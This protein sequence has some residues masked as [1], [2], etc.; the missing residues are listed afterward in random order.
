MTTNPHREK[1]HI[2]ANSAAKN[3][4]WKGEKNPIYRNGD[5]RVTLGTCLG[6]ATSSPSGLFMFFV[7]EELFRSP[8]AH[9]TPKFELLV[10]QGSSKETRDPQTWGAIAL[11]MGQ[12]RA[13]LPN[14]STATLNPLCKV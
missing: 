12:L 2:I 6:L 9:S 5:P 13:L 1:C 8:D 3:R 4:M 14:G 7:F 11:G 10:Y